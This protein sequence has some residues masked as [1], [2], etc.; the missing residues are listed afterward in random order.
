MFTT[1][2]KSVKKCKIVWLLLLPSSLSLLSHL[3]RHPIR[4]SFQRQRILE[5]LDM[6]MAFKT[7][8]RKNTKDPPF[9]QSKKY[10]K[11]H[12]YTPIISMHILEIVRRGCYFYSK[13]KKCANRAKI[14]QRHFE[15]SKLFGKIIQ[16]IIILRFSIAQL[17]GE[18][19]KQAVPWHGGTGLFGTLEYIH[20]ISDTNIFSS[21]K[22]LSL[23]RICQ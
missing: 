9:I 11:I 21:S 3:V 12:Y 14:N 23:K 18:A 13:Y 10:R 7:F 17:C 6:S 22:N 1:F 19:K 5:H 2:F 4:I 20:K 16:D 15:S 8:K